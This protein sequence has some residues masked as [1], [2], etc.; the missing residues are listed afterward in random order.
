MLQGIEIQEDYANQ[1]L[2]IVFGKVF[3]SKYWNNFFMLEMVGEF[4]NGFLCATGSMLNTIRL[5]LTKS[6]T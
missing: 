1:Y 2:K 5:K 3:C 6:H 4:S